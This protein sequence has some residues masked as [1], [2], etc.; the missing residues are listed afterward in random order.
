[1][2]SLFSIILLTFL[3]DLLVTAAPVTGL[4]FNRTSIS[5]IDCGTKPE[6]SSWMPCVTL[7]QNLNTGVEQTN[8]MKGL[9]IYTDAARDYLNIKL[10][11]KQNHLQLVIIGL[12]GSQILKKELNVAATDLK[13]DIRN[14]NK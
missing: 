14:Y 5:Y 7:M 6:F 9:T 4:Q 2:K 12:T 1:M 3:N 10:S 13:P 11:E 8:V